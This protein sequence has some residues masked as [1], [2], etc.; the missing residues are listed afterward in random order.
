MSE[1]PDETITRVSSLTGRRSIACF[2]LLSLLA[3]PAFADVPL[4]QLRNET[5]K[6]L[7]QEAVLDAGEAK[8]DAI[9]ALCDLYVVIRNDDRYAGCPVQQGTGT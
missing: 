1:Y 9:A 2:A 6:L 5:R 4:T 7:R 8:D 3:A